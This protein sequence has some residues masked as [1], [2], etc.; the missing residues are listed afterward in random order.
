MGL[1]RAFTSPNLC[2]ALVLLN[3]SDSESRIIFKLL[4]DLRENIPI[5]V[6]A[7]LHFK[8]KQDVIFCIDNAK[9]HLKAVLSPGYNKFLS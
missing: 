5:F 4:L 2:R 3:F 8:T 1:N 6:D 9:V 7:L